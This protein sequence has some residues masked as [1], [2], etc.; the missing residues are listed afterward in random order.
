MRSKPNTCLGW[1]TETSWLRISVRR[2]SSWRRCACLTS[3][4]KTQ[5]MLEFL[6]LV[7]IHC[8]LYLVRSFNSCDLKGCLSQTPSKTEK[9][10]LVTF[11]HNFF[12][13]TTFYRYRSGRR[14]ALLPQAC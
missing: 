10:L 3:A 12:S 11:K 7:R 13:S 14:E 9:R 1:S 2:R 6:H 5:R 4:L 8:D